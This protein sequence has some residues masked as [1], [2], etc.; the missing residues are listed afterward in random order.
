MTFYCRHQTTNL[1]NW[2]VNHT[3]LSLVPPSDVTPSMRRDEDGAIVNTLTI[4][5]SL[6]YNRTAVECEA[7][8]RDGSQPE[9]ST[10]AVLLVEGNAWFFVTLETCMFQSLIIL[11]IILEFHLIRCSHKESNDATTTTKRYIL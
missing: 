7:V 4:S 1:I 2:R 9:V 6:E 10:A 5:A 8:F 11:I 3:L